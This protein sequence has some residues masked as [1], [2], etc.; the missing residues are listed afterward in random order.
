M[1]STRNA[2]N[3]SSVLEGQEKSVAVVSKIP[4]KTHPVA[5]SFEV[6]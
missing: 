5:A 2:K 4:E 3:A 6:E 1:D